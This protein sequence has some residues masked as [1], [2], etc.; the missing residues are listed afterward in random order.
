MLVFR[1]PNV[2]QII[3]RG[4]MGTTEEAIKYLD[5]GYYLGFTGYLCKVIKIY[6]YKFKKYCN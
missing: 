3:I 5:N 4:F 1:F 2:S 6:I